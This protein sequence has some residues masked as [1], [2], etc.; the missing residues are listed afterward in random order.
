MKFIKKHLILFF[1]IVGIILII[2]VFTQDIGDGTD[3]LLLLLGLAIITISPFTILYFKWLFKQINNNKVRKKSRLKEIEIKSN[4]SSLIYAVCKEITKNDKLVLEDF[5]FCLNEPRMYYQM[6]ID[7]FKE[8]GIDNY[9]TDEE[10]QWLSMINILIKHNYT[11]ELD[12]KCDFDEFNGNLQILKNCP[13]YELT[14]SSNEQENIEVWIEEI[15]KQWRSNSYSLG[16]ID[17]DSDSYVLFVTERDKISLLNSLAS[18]VNYKIYTI[19][20]PE[21][22]NE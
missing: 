9:S 20:N 19:E 7:D 1:E 15:N 21:E 5:E 13:E 2:I 6:N 3:C 8:R 17:I 11:V 16:I 22:E 14:N 18:R 10:I 12:W 4:N